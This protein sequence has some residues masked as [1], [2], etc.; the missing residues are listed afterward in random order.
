MKI[1]FCAKDQYNFSRAYSKN[2]INIL[3]KENNLLHK[4]DFV[5]ADDFKNNI[6]LYKDVDAIFG[7]WGCIKFDKYILDNLKN[8]KIIFYAAGSIRPIISNELWERGIK[9]TS[10][11]GVIAIN[12]AEFTLASIIFGLKGANK[13]N[14]DYKHVKIKNKSDLAIGCYKSTV[15]II[16]LGQVGINVFKILKNF[17]F[18]IVAYD[19]YKINTFND[20]KITFYSDINDL[21]KNSDA[22]TVHLPLI[23]ET[24]YFIK[25]MHIL[26]MKQNSVFINTSRG[27]VVNENELIESLKIRNDIFAY[28]DVTEIEPAEK[29][30]ELY[31]MDNV[32]LTPHI[33]GGNLHEFNRNGDL[34]LKEYYNFIS[35]KNLEWEIT[36]DILKN[37]A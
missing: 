20:P 23:K 29:S 4:V 17:D 5:T 27:S 22:V 14:S 12:V 24:K 15:G 3:K 2:V 36:E 33:S 31:D 25:K 30:N 21:F 11:Y 19:P 32:F 9:I 8:L 37:M 18:K 6:H 7:T 16:G 34:M 28:L 10:A 35:N 1:V 26:L 13:I